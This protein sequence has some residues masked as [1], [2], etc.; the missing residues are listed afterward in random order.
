[1]ALRGDLAPLFAE[2]PGALVLSELERARQAEADALIAGY[3][4]LERL[5]YLAI[6]VVVGADL[7]T[8]I[9][10]MGADPADCPEA[11]LRAYEEVTWVALESRVQLAGII[12]IGEAF[13]RAVSADGGI[14]A[15]HFDTSGLAERSG[16]SPESPRARE[17]AELTAGATGAPLNEH[18][19]AEL[20]HSMTNPDPTSAAHRHAARAVIG[21]TGLLNRYLSLMATI[22]GTPQPDAE[23]TGVSEEWLAAA[24]GR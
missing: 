15:S 21:F 2:L 17:I 23:D 12:P 4:G 10:R 6:A 22:N 18:D 13:S 9:R 5:L 7:G 8:V 24:L 16:L 20:R 3:E 19:L 1:M 11:G 14:V